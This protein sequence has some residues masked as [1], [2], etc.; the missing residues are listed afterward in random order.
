MTARTRP[1]SDP[2]NLGVSPDFADC[3][4]GQKCEAG[5]CFWEPPT[6]NLGDAC[7]FSQQC[8]SLSCAT[9]DGAQICSED[10]VSGP[11]DRCPDGFECVAPGLGQHGAGGP[12]ATDKGGCCSTGDQGR[13]AV[14]VNI[15]LGCLLGLVIVRR[16]RR[17]CTRD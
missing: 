14:V 7:D 3:A 8:V 16:R 13:G 12:I 17:R 11:N 1:P 5:K 4:E 6:L 10:C 15:G 9:V 2:S